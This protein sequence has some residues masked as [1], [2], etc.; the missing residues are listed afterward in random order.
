MEPFGILKMLQSLLEKNPS[1]ADEP[2]PPPPEE[3]ETSERDNAFLKLMER[4]ERI[5]Q[6]VDKRK[7]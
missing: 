1:Q 7:K 5:S 3:K 6:S 2:S 4:H